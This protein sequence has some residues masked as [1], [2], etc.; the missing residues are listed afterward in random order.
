[1]LMVNGGIILHLIH[2]LEVK[3]VLRRLDGT[4][5]TICQKRKDN[6]IKLRSLIKLNEQGPTGAAPGGAPVPLQTPPPTGVEPTEDPSAM[7]APTL[8]N[9]PSPEDPGEY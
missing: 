5:N 9:T 2:M 7:S 6:M 8:D 3:N 4:K 1:M